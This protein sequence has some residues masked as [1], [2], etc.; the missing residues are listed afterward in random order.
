LL[1]PF[2]TVVAFKKFCASIPLKG[3]LQTKIDFPTGFPNNRLADDGFVFIFRAPHL[4]RNQI[5]DDPMAGKNRIFL[6]NK[7]IE[8]LIIQLVN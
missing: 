8:N 6:T 2:V 4:S 5:F 1:N 7:S 3:D